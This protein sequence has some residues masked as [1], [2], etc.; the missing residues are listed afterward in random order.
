MRAQEK[1][2][3]G[4][5]AFSMQKNGNAGG[6]EKRHWFGNMHYIPLR[7]ERRSVGGILFEDVSVYF[8]CTTVADSQLLLPLLLLLLLLPSENFR[9]IGPEATVVAR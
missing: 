5:K 7:M 9:W 4:G 3:P 1:H 6:Q 2:I 8:H